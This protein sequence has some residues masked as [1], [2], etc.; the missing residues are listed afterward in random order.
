MQRLDVRFSELSVAF[1][2]REAVGGSD[3]GLV[4]VLVVAFHAN[5]GAALCFS[6][7][8]RLHQL[9]NIL[10]FG[11]GSLHPVFRSDLKPHV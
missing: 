11:D 3:S 6:D 7:L 5:L 4:A 10:V 2:Q 1:D 8:L 9:G